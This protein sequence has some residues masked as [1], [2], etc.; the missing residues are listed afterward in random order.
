M[1]IKYILQILSFGSFIGRIRKGTNTIC[2]T[3][4]DGP[5]P[6]YTRKVLDVL[7]ENNI[8]AVFFLIGEK[9]EKYPEIARRIIDEGHVIGG[10]TYSHKEITS[11]TRKEAANDLKH[12]RDIF[13]QYLEHDSILF[14][15]PRGRMNIKNTLLIMFKGYKI[16]HWSITYSDYLKDG[17]DKLKQR[18]SGRLPKSGDIILLHDNNPYTLESLPYLIDICNKNN[19]RFLTL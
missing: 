18:I 4:D 19:L 17:T 6:E 12:T 8:K 3:F 15:P 13:N 2:L 9:V 10:H 14:R 11:M 16:I 5:N 1:L 7:K